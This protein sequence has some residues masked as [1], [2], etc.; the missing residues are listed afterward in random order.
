MF[1]GTYPKLSIFPHVPS[2]SYPD[3]KH[4]M[5]EKKIYI[6]IYMNRMSRLI[7]SIIHAVNPDELVKNISLVALLKKHRWIGKNISLVAS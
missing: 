2:W 3:L 7:E 1:P 4:T 5:L 6:Y